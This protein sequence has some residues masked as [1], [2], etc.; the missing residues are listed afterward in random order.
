[1]SDATLDAISSNILL[2]CPQ[3]RRPTLIWHGGEPM[4]LP[5]AWYAA[6]F[7]RLRVGSGGAPLE[8]AFQTN[9]VGTNDAWITLWRRWGVSI[10]LSLDGPNDIHD[11]RRRTRAGGGSHGLTMA[12]AARLQSEGIPFHV[13]SVLTPASL[14]A[15][16]KMYDFYR[17]AGISH[18]AFNVEEDEGQDGG[19]S[20]S[21]A[22]GTVAAYCAFLARF[23]ART[24]ADPKPVIC[25]EIEGVRSLIRGRHEDRGRNLQVAPFEIVTVGV[26]GGL[27]TF[28][29]ELL[30][31]ADARFGNFTFGNVRDGGGL[32]A[33]ARHPAYLRARREIA[34]GVRACAQSCAYFEVC[35][36]GAPSNKYF[37]L[38]RLDGTETLY[39][40]LTIQATLETTLEAIESRAARPE[41]VTE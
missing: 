21:R 15:P 8:H 39:C 12:A 37:E 1:M 40:K 16:D 18:V 26:D 19:S 5:P 7:E 32:A 10:G 25:R 29:P 27:S 28:S 30:G 34:R 14:A 24:A 13:I 3:D 23:I 33:M 2:P 17:S 22:P 4:T 6:A 31:V 9:G 20:L 11:A 38:G 36:G 35:G 41:G